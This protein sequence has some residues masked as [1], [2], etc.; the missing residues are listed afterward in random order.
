MLPIQTQIITL[1]VSF[2]AGAKVQ[3]FFAKPNLGEKKI[4]PSYK[5]LPFLYPEKAT[6]ADQKILTSGEYFRPA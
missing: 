6:F 5:H 3:H 1:K 4:L 2:L